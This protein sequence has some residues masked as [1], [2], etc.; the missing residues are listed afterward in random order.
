M[1]G[2]E[3]IAASALNGSLLLHCMTEQCLRGTRT[4]PGTHWHGHTAQVGLLH[5]SVTVSP[6][7]EAMGLLW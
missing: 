2:T 4:W 6:Q 7:P 3:E 5:T 1:N